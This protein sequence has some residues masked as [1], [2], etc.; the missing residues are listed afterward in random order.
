MI[1]GGAVWKREGL[2]AMGRRHIQRQ[3]D[4]KPD[5][6]AETC[7][8]KKGN[9]DGQHIGRPEQDMNSPEFPVG[10]KAKSNTACTGSRTPRP[11][12]PD[13]LTSQLR[14]CTL[15]KFHTGNY[16]RADSSRYHH[17]T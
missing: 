8:L 14:P 15:G 9:R 1:D 12:P 11:S 17:T 16:H 2:S 7:S 4:T 10:S 5:H 6:R 13:K 3:R